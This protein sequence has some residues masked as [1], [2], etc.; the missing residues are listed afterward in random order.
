MFAVRLFL[1]LTKI[2]VFCIN[3]DKACQEE[4]K[5]SYDVSAS[6]IKWEE[7]Q[8]EVFDEKAR[9]LLQIILDAEEGKNFDNLKKYCEDR[10]NNSDAPS[11]YYKFAH[12]FILLKK[13]KNNNFSLI[14]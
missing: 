3:N 9:T 13:R 12:D 7:Y 8:W 11:K 6:F 10:L 5:Y 14:F 1:L 2:G 4:N